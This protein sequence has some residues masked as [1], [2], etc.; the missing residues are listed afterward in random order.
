MNS[1]TRNH[2]IT[3]EV[4]A[5]DDDGKP[6]NMIHQALVTKI[7]GREKNPEVQIFREKA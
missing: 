3:L 5:I 6:K 7:N 1:H 2:Y 4:E